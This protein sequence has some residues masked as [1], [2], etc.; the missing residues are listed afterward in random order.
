MYRRLCSGGGG[1]GG[2]RKFVSH[3][4]KLYLRSSLSNLASLK[5]LFPAKLTDF[6]SLS[7]LSVPKLKKPWKVL[8]SLNT[9]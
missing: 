2:R 1:E 4:E 3:F 9:T 8:L 6:P 7:N 5:A